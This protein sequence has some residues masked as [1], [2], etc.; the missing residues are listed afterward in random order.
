MRHYNNYGIV[1]NKNR[2]YN[3]D[4]FKNFKYTKITS[5]D[6][7]DIFIEET[8][9]IQFNNLKSEI[10]EYG[11]NIGIKHALRDENEQSNLYKQFCDKYGK[12][13][14]DKIVC[15]V[16]TS[17]HHTGLAI[18]VEIMID[19]KWI[20]NNEHIE[21]TEPI[22]RKIHPYLPKYGFILRYPKGKEKIT[23]IA[24][25]PWH[26]RYV[27]INLAEY[28]NKNNLLLDEIK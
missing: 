27:G 23:G 12:D 21:I 24:Y 7:R 16:G 14:A 9:N 22:L 25:E 8:T 4:E 20:T 15:P 18:D 2:K 1:V 10:K 3:P 28:L 6:G 13:Y 17:E 19:G 11:I 26:I 5:T